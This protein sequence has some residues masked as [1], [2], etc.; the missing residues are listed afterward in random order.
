[1]N[2]ISITMQQHD[3]SSQTTLPLRSNEEED[4]AMMSN[5]LSSLPEHEEGEQEGEG[6][7]H[8]GRVTRL[9]AT[10]SSSSSSQRVTSRFQRMANTST[11]AMEESWNGLF[12]SSSISDL[13]Q[14]QQ[15]QQQQLHKKLGHASFTD[16]ALYAQNQ[17]H[18]HHDSAAALLTNNNNNNNNKQQLTS[19]DLQAAKKE[20]M[21]LRLYRMLQSKTK[22]P[23]A[24]R[25]QR[26]RQAGGEQDERCHQSDSALLLLQSTNMEDTSTSTSTSGSGSSSSTMFY[27]SK[28]PNQ[29]RRAVLESLTQSAPSCSIDE[30]DSDT[31]DAF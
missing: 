12:L 25:K 31:Y 11:S 17:H 14:P 9:T 15:Q 28:H 26:H 10:S 19:S 20:F 18:Q 24:S 4:P 21:K 30:D 3:H 1:M 27:K 2:P 8:S 7:L 5:I 22:L 16:L 29:C 13:N 23:A 6:E